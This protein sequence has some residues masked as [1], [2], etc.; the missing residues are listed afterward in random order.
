MNDDVYMP[1][2]VGKAISKFDL[3]IQGDDT[4]D[5]ISEENPHFC[6]LTGLY[7]V[8]K[9]MKPVDYIGLCHYRRYFN[10]HDHGTWF[11][12]YTVVKSKDFNK[13]D[14][15]LPD[16]DKL[17]SRYDVVISKSR[18]FPYSFAVHYAVCQLSEDFRTLCSII[19]EQYPE[20]DDDMQAVLFSSNKLS[21]YNMAIFKWKDFDKYC[22]WLFNVLFEARSRIN[23]ENYSPV[24]S[25]IWGYMSECL[26]SVWIHHQNMRVKKLPVYLISDDTEEYSFLYRLQRNFRMNL[27]FSFVKPRVKRNVDSFIG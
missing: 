18:I 21:P 7:W 23:I 11:S 13:L 24:Q 15:S 19:H 25:R 26:L 17:F 5:N 2:H 14:L 16:M 8:W 1:I 10:F 4:G 3:G 20:Y 22:Q 9:N 12:D 6:E 27:A